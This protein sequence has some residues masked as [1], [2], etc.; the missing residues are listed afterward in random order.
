MEESGTPS[1]PETRGREW[2]TIRECADEIR[3]DVEIVRRWCIAH[4]N[5]NEQGLP[6]AHFG[7]DL[8][9]S[10]KRRNRRIHV[11][12]WEAFK[13]SR[14][15]GDH[16][17]PPMRAETVLR[18]QPLIIPTRAERRQCR[19]EEKLRQKQAAGKGPKRAP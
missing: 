10:A 15:P 1:E 6:S 11:E 17:L 19:E 14:R 2:L 7:V 13:A 8:S 3:V 4:E 18:V 16:R 9:D 5:G 12:D